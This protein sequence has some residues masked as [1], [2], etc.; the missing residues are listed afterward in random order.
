MFFGLITP[1]EGIDCQLSRGS[2]V[3]HINSHPVPSEKALKTASPGKLANFKSSIFRYT[4]LWLRQRRW[5]SGE[6]AYGP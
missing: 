1:T 6:Q 2:G 5:T 4:Y 3:Y